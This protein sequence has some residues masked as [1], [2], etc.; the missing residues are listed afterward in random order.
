[1]WHLGKHVAFDLVLQWQ[2]C[3]HTV[4]SKPFTLKRSESLS[5]A[6]KWAPKSHGWVLAVMLRSVYPHQRQY[7]W[8]SGGHVHLNTLLVVILSSG[9]IANSS[10][11]L[12]L[13]SW[14]TANAAS[15]RGALP[16]R[17]VT[18]G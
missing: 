11:S 6:T 3:V 16:R 7:L 9:H 15:A 1:M 18:I 13:I 17:L 14:I 10:R 12:C 4:D 5:V 2:S 8:I